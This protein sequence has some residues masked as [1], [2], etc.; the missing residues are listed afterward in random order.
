VSAAA[1]FPSNLRC[2]MAPDSVAVIGASSDPSRIG[3]RPI[4]WMRRAGFQGAIYPVNP[5]R[6][7]VQGLKS[8]ASIDDLPATP[9]A[10]IVAVPAP[11]VLATVEALG[12]RGVGAAVVFSSG[13]AEVGGQGNAAQQQLVQ[14]AR[15]HGMRLLGPNCLGLFN[16]PL[17]WYPTFTSSFEG[18]WPLSGRIGVVSQ[19]G[20]FGSYLVTLARNRG[21]GTPQCVTTGNQADVTVGEIIHWYAQDPAVDVIAAYVEGVTRA[22]VFVNA[23]NAARQ[24]R[25][26]VIL[27]KVGRSAVGHHAAQSHTA[28]MAGD[29]AVTAAVLR[30]FGVVQ[31]RSAEELLDVAYVATRRVYPAANTLGVA[32]VSGGVGVL[33]SDIAEDEGLA[34]PPMPEAAQQSLRALLPY[35]SPVNPVDCTAQ[36]VNDSSLVQRFTEAMV[37]QGGYTSVLSFYAQLAD[38]PVVGDRLLADLS[39]VRQRHPDRLFVVSA[40][41]SD[42]RRRAYD[43]AGLVVLEDAARATR[44]IAAMGRLG[45]AFARPPAQA[46]ASMD[47]I[48]LSPAPLSESQAKQLLAEHGMACSPERLCIDQEAAVLAARELGWPVVLKIVSPDIAHKTEIGGVLLN[49]DSEA[50]VRAGFDTL[51]QRAARHAPDARIDG[52]LVARQLQGGVECLMGVQCDPVFG[53][54]AVFGL[55]GIFVEALQDVVL[56]RCPF[57]EREAERMIRSIRAA[58]V[59]TGMRNRPPADIPALARMLS[60]LSVFAHRAGDTLESIDLNPVLALPAGQG[61]FALDALVQTRDPSREVSNP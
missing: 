18:G 44:A 4:D 6:D 42:E 9:E 22:D 28:S 34:M 13:F 17:G 20:A 43:D 35:A 1:D 7:E 15:R 51:Q 53:P 48:A 37:E 58:A 10:A 8:Y 61:A 31:V 57:D 40:T 30:E 49:V 16:A 23:L 54:V 56:H 2:L 21:I 60:R 50:A 5:T 38:V 12:A 29:D 41:M 52:V 11:Q 33:I 59:L 36:A 47:P 55:G 26:P 32:T 25:K 24:A 27:L 46:A 3:G 14:A 39:A 19:S 45:E